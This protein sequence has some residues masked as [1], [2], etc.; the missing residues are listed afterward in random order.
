M[1]VTLFS[2]KV[3]REKVVEPI[4]KEVLPVFVI[5]VLFPI[6]GPRLMMV[7]GRGRK[8]P[9]RKDLRFGSNP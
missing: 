1:F 5:K 9:S 7:F 2:L 3:E 8:Q 4:A 6:P